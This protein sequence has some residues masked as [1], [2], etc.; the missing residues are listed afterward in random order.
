MQED[1]RRARHL[2]EADAILE[3]ALKRCRQIDMV[4]YEADI[5]LACARLYY[6][7]GDRNQAKMTCMEAL[8]ITNR[9][10]F[11][12]LR[13]DVRNF[14]AQLE[15]EEG[16][17]QQAIEQA[18]LTKKD[19]ACNAGVYCYRSAFDLANTLLEQANTYRS[20]EDF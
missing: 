2:H 8:G 10:D 5:L 18:Q 4:D 12:V 7:K 17:Q 9:S 19:A 6:A 11:R 14:L 3:E 1:T 16:N 13:A 20:L 15:L